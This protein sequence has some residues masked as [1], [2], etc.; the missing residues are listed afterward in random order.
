MTIAHQVTVYLAN[1]NLDPHPWL[2]PRSNYL[3]VE[4][5]GYELMSLDGVQCNTS[6]FLAG[7]ADLKEVSLLQ[8]RTDLQGKLKC[9]KMRLRLSA[10]KIRSLTAEKLESLSAHKLGHSKCI[11]VIYV[12]QN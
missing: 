10:R 6:P 2:N 9:W 3:S 1:I 7:C 8:P 12:D 4:F 11:I 5:L